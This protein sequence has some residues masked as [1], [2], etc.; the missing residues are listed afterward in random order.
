MPLLQQYDPPAW[1]P[2]FDGIPGQREAWHAHVQA[3][4]SAW[5]EAVALEP[6][7]RASSPFHDASVLDA[8]PSLAQDILWN[9]FPWELLRRFDR[10]AAYDEA[11]K[12]D[13]VSPAA[14]EARCRRGTEYCEWHVHR[15]PVTG[16]MC[17][18]TFTTEAPEYWQALWGGP[19]AASRT[20]FP[21]S[22]ERVLEL[23]RTLVDPRIG[24][25]DLTVQQ[26]FDSPLGRLS[27][28]DYDPYNAWN[29]AHGIV[30][31]T[32]PPNQLRAEIKLAAQASRCFMDSTG[33]PVLQ[34]EAIVAG[35][36]MA[37]PNRSSDLA[38][39]GSIGALARQGRRVT[40]A[41]PVGIYI[42]HIDLA[43]WEFRGEPV[44]PRC[45]QAVRGSGRHVTRLVV[46]PPVQGGHLDELSIGGVPVTH[47]GQ[48]A[49]CVTVRLRAYASI[50]RPLP[51]PHCRLSTFGTVERRGGRLV[52]AADAPL[53]SAGGQL[54]SG[55]VR[56]FGNDF[57]P[58]APR[59]QPPDCGCP[60]ARD[61]L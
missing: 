38:I 7:R 48:I 13:P 50:A 36:D 30:H 16:R 46:R 41:N 5:S 26:A 11:E 39:A 56:A 44:G 2:D 57:D 35:T 17:S 28:G 19:L 53:R 59:A 37:E 23:Y 27:P 9:A 18:V 20:R 32:A 24:M 6:E 55:A 10:P 34:P 51:V 33:R 21:G 45:V 52:Q 22:P 40:L 3:Q 25:A 43:G 31:L 49:E 12:T 15:S 54:P 8:G 47:G 4:M 60:D 58:A 42:D 29:V 61:R 14:P 1:L